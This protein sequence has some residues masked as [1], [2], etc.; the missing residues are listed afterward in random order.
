M[1]LKILHVKKKSQWTSTPL[2]LL[3]PQYW[4]R[5]V[6]NTWA[7]IKQRVPCKLISFFL[8]GDNNKLPMLCMRSE[9]MHAF[10]AEQWDNTNIHG[11]GEILPDV[12]AFPENP[13]NK[14]P[15][16]WFIYC[17]LHLYFVIHFLKIFETPECDF[18]C[19]APFGRWRETLFFFL[20]R[21]LSVSIKQRSN[22]LI[23]ASTHW[24]R[25]TWRR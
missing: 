16:C 8:N 17:F 20:P 23:H 3:L 10:D 25:S 12:I 5:Q 24:S 2:S 14:L 7:E 15:D 9:C 21:P 11:W 22:V 18:F 1:S 4:N 19:L 6:D 13:M